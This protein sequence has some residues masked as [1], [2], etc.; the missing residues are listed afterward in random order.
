MLGEHSTSPLP[1]TFTANDFVYPVVTANAGS[2]AK[3]TWVGIRGY[4]TTGNP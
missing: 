3:M 4:Q 2:G 1:H